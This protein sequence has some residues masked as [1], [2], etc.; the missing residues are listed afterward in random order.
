M[1][2]HLQLNPGSWAY[3][4]VFQY[5]CEYK[6]KTLF[7]IFFHLFRVQYSSANQMQSHGLITLMHVACC[8]RLF[9]E[10][11]K[12]FEYQFFLV[13]LLYKKVHAIVCT[14]GFWQG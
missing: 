7:V 2:A 6:G 4:K 1:I 3:I 12:H 9:L 11:M 14:I 8:F 13:V 10:I 5:L